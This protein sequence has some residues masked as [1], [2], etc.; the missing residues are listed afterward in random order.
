MARY[1]IDKRID[2]VDKLSEFDVAG[3]RF[4]PEQSSNT[5][6]VFVRLEKDRP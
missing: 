2:T 1:I 6:L 4:A 5:E 3:Y